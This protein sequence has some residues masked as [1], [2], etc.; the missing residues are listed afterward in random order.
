M[1]DSTQEEVQESKPEQSGQRLSRLRRKLASRYRRDKEKHSKEIVI[2]KRKKSSEFSDQKRKTLNKPVN[3]KKKV[4][5][6]LKED[7]ENVP[8][9][10]KMNRIKLSKEA[11][12][13]NVVKKQYPIIDLT[14][15]YC[16]IDVDD[17]DIQE[18]AEPKLV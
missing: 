14:K 10:E 4:I 1:E 9:F 8:N 7:T 18:I 16:T 17:D 3:K 5:K 12:N 13:K 6:E 15:N 2:D 11:I